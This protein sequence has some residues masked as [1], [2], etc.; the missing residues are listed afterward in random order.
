[1]ES[2]VL[3]G[4]RHRAKG[5]PGFVFGLM[6][7]RLYQCVDLV[8]EGAEGTRVRRLQ[9]FVV[10]EMLVQQEGKHGPRFRFMTQVRSSTV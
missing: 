7:L 9:K 4:D 6:L 1:V 5:G 2:P 3:A 10:E 8:G